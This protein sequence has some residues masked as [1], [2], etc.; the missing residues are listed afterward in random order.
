MGVHVNTSNASFI[1]CHRILRKKGVSNNMFMLALQ[2]PELADV[3]PHDPMISDENRLKVLAEVK[4]NPWYFFREVL[5]IPIVGGLVPFEMHLGNMALVHL[6]LRNVNTIL[7]LPRQHYKTITS[8]C[9]FLYA[10]EFITTNST[11]IFSNKEAKDAMLNLDRYKEIR[12]RLPQWMLTTSRDDV[13]NRL[14]IRNALRFNNINTVSSAITEEQAS[15]MARGLTSPMIWFDEFAFLKFNEEIYKTASPALSRAAENA[16]LMG[17]PHFKLITTTPNS[18]G[19]ESAA[20]CHGMMENA[21]KF[22][23]ALYDAT[24]EETQEYIQSNSSNDFVFVEYHYNELGR[25]AAWLEKQKRDLNN[26]PDAIDREILLKWQR[27]SNISVFPKEVLDEVESHERK[28]IG[29]L[30]LGEGRYLDLYGD[31]LL[32]RDY[33]IG[34]DPAG[35]VVRD[36]SSI[37]VIDA[38]TMR[39]VAHYRSN[40]IE[41]DSL[42]K[43]ISQIHKRFFP[44]AAVA[45]ERSPICLHMIQDLMETPLQKWMVHHMVS[46]PSIK[47]RGGAKPRSKP[48][49]MKP[50][51]KRERIAFGVPANA[52]SREAMM[53]IM[54]HEVNNRPDV[55]VVPDIIDQILCLQRNKRGRVHHPHNKN[56]DDLMAYLIARYALGYLPSTSRIL[57]RRSSGMVEV[58]QQVRAFNK[59]TDDMTP[60]S[61]PDILEERIANAEDGKLLSSDLPK[62]KTRETQWFLDLNDPNVKD[63]TD[64]PRDWAMLGLRREA[65]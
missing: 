35:G 42:G 13:E 16:E 17:K 51:S 44:Y 57:G 47:T 6:A 39:P 7:V 65:N 21:A 55:F 52:K 27:S 64:R 12:K 58:I 32:T 46:D 15:K 29:E 53:D 48:K 3:D 60:K 14:D 10:Y 9:I 45:I 54:S 43:L 24:Q 38:D 40:E 28:P 37:V 49:V 8:I 5:R 20:Y 63:P 61:R 22:R 50:D 62:P 23:L 2:Q 41:L 18:L 34:V 11:I 31:V 36:Y 25:D 19:F 33:V 26:D 4:A 59:T 56:D 1:Q 30:S